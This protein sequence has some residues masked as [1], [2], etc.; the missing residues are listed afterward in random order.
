MDNY[1]KKSREYILDIEKRLKKYDSTVKR[2]F[3]KNTTEVHI[4]D[5]IFFDKLT[6]GEIVA[7]FRDLKTVYR[8]AIASYYGVN[9]K[10]FD[11]WI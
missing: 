1:Q 10:V 5:Y 7:I 3:S 2:Y 4:P 11:S 8:K 6:F 9:Y